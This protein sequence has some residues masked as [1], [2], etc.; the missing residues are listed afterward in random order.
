M[1]TELTKVRENLS[2]SLGQLAEFAGFNRSLGQIYGLLY[3]NSKALSLGEIAEELGVSKGN[4]SLNTRV[5]ER[6]GLIKLFNRAADRRDYYEVEIDFWKV[7]QGILQGRERKKL[8]DIGSLLTK[9]LKDLEKLKSSNEEKDAKFYHERLQHMLEFYELFDQLFSALLALD[10]FQANSSLQ[11]DPDREKKQELIDEEG[12][13]L[14]QQRD[15]DPFYSDA[16]YIP[17]AALN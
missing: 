13:N 9:S 8:D 6:W 2:Q 17:V 16:F 7:I 12:A 4:V 10:D 5:M 15:Y 14:H 1:A 11:P 3:L